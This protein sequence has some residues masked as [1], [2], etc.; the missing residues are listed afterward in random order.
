MYWFGRG[1]YL[2]YLALETRGSQKNF[3]KSGTATLRSTE[4]TSLWLATLGTSS[5][6]VPDPN[7]VQ[8][9][10]WKARAHGFLVRGLCCRKSKQRWRAEEPREIFTPS[11]CGIMVI[12]LC[13]TTLICGWDFYDGKCCREICLF[14]SHR[15]QFVG[16]MLLQYTILFLT[17]LFCEICSVFTTMTCLRYKIHWKRH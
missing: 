1:T 3:F 8:S 12:R 9:I 10:Q 6:D 14:N 7:P 15:N 13:P 17:G 5:T 4:P 11:L 2:F 16:L